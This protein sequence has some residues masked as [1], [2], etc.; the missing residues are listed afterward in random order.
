MYPNLKAEMARFG[1]SYNDIAKLLGRSQQWVD[2]RMRG[3]ASLSISDAMSIR[4]KFFPNLSCEYLF[5]EEPMVK[6]PA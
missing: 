1:V 6:A 2:S 5:A 3:N 4:N